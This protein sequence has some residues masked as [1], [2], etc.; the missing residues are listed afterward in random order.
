MYKT[1]DVNKVSIIVNSRGTVVWVGRAT[2][3]WQPKTKMKYYKQQ[4]KQ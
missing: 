1:T 2:R 3:R 4:C